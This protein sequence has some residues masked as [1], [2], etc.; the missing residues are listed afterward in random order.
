LVDDPLGKIYWPYIGIRGKGRK[1]C[2]CDTELCYRWRFVGSPLVWSIWNDPFRIQCASATQTE[3]LQTQYTLNGNSGYFL[4]GDFEGLYPITRNVRGTLW[5]N[6]STAQVNGTA[7]L[8]S[9]VQ[10]S[11]VMGVQPGSAS[12]PDSRIQR[13]WYAFG[14]GMEMSF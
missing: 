9:T 1:C 11:T 4:E 5:L 13:S 14:L 2:G 10:A 3:I 7:N 8:S 12:I 6:L